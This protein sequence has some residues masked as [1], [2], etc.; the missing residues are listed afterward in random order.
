VPPRVVVTSTTGLSPETVTISGS[1][2]T[3]STTSGFA[4][5]L[6]ARTIFARQRVEAS[7]SYC[8]RNV[9]GEGQ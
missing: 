6:E 8:T 1:V 3:F 5:K 4:E 7:Q 2:A 9:L